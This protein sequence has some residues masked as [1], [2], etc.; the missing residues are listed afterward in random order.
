M[1]QHK[2]LMRKFA[3]WTVEQ[4]SWDS[5]INGSIETKIKQDDENNHY[6]FKIGDYI[7]LKERNP[8]NRAISNRIVLG[9]IKDNYFIMIKSY[10]LNAKYSEEQEKEVIAYPRS[11]IEDNFKRIN[12]PQ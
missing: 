8:Q 6:Q 3:D 12:R 7:E 1:K 2:S 10:N 9:C 11:F 5:P 4:F